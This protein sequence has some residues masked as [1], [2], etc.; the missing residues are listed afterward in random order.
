M[1]ILFVVTAF[2]PEQAIGSV[3]MSKFAK[4]LHAAGDTISIIS[5][6]PPCWANRD[7]T[8]WFPGLEKIKWVQIGQSRLFS[9]TL[10][11]G[12]DITIGKNYALATK[13]ARD[14]GL[15]AER[16]FRKTRS[17]GYF[18]F[19]LVKAYDWVNQVKKSARI[20]LKKEKYNLILTS[21]PS[22]ASPLAGIA[23][24]RMGF[25]DRLIIDFRD[26]FSYDGG[27][28]YILKNLL[29]K[30][31]F[32]HCDLASFV[33]R[34]VKSKV[35]HGN[36]NFINCHVA[37]NGYDNYDNPIFKSQ[38]I[39]EDKNVLRFC[40][41]GSLYG[42]KRNLDLFFRSLNYMIMQK[43]IVHDHIELHYAG[44]EG[45]I[46]KRQALQ[47]GVADLVIDHGLVSRQRS[48]ELQ[49][50]SDICLLTTWN[51]PT[52]QGI[53][54]GKMFEIFLLRKPI[55]AIVNGTLPG[56]ESKDLIEEVGAGV[57]LE[58]SSPTVQKDINHM[59]EWIEDCYQQKMTNGCI[60]GTYNTRVHRYDY[61]EIV[62][63]L[64]KSMQLIIE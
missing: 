34:G 23:L 1:K 56:S 64:R 49:N 25:A 57:C 51:T 41:C 22:L 20:I 7:E 12:R 13:V 42:G 61:S 27:I 43:R 38:D 6:K 21:Y 29:E 54:T 19:S 2:Y 32:H 53:L 37:P 10:G 8:M 55:L 14:R 28:P 3:R 15:L 24:K 47:A 60:R 35:V 26:P 5:M 11:R 44:G 16:V 62:G 52:E 18:I 39:N 59:N 50:K 58:E 4:Y 30:Y 45:P 40:Y 63:E 36:N 46:F 33:S 31:F 17:I 9:N 48:L